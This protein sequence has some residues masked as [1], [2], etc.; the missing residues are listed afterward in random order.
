MDTFR[1]RSHHYRNDRA[2][3]LADLLAR[4]LRSYLEATGELLEHP[5]SACHTD[6]EIFTD[7]ARALGVRV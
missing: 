5:C 3:Q 6:A 2:E 4:V 1:R 7:K